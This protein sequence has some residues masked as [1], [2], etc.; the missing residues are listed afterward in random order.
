MARIS[1]ADYYSEYHGH[2]L[3]DLQAMVEQLPQGR[4]TIYLLGDS[5][6]DNKFWLSAPPQPALNGYERI[7]R[8]PQST[9]DVTYWINYGLE[10]C[11]LGGDFC[12]INTAIEESTLGLRNRGKTLLPQDAFVANAVTEKDVLIVSCGGNDIA[13]RPSACTIASIVP[14]LMSPDWMIS[15]GIAPGLMHFVNLFKNHTQDFVESVV[16][17]RK[18]RVVVVCMLYYLDEVGRGGWAD[19]VLGLLGYNS[20]PGKLQ[21]IMRKI[22]ELAT[23]EITIKGVPTVVP[24]PLFEALDGKRTTDYVARVEPSVQGG[25]KLAALILDRLAPVLGQ[26]QAPPPSADSLDADEPA[27]S[28]QMGA[29]TSSS[30]VRAM[31]AAVHLE[32]R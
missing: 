10:T 12:A 3:E 27:G 23:C 1:S 18:P 5:T 25:A 4:G 17:H 6:F 19:R 2:R 31:P 7:L 11:G 26:Q 24:V 15:A 28:H 14:L 30:A 20:N 29:T 13:L 22:Y 8:P 9:A 21:L 16:A 32:N